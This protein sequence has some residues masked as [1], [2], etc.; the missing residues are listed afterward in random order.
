MVKSLRC[1]GRPRDLSRDTAI[2]EAA[3]CLF[4]KVG[5]ERLSIDAIAHEA[6]VSKATI[7][8]RWKNKAELMVAAVSHYSFSD[9]PNIDTGTL[10]GDLIEIL[11]NRIRIL[12]GEDGQVLMGVMTAAK[13][14]PELGAMISREIAKNGGEIHREIISRAVTRGEIPAGADFETILEVVPP[15][16]TYRIFMT[17]ESVDKKFVEHLVDDVLIPS[18]KAV[19]LNV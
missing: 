8:R 3:L 7:Y 18:L 1:N 19:K 9:T 12:K 4:R 17:G 2:E 16:L 13:S 11:Q 15:I 14:D 6:Q 10:R 5:Y